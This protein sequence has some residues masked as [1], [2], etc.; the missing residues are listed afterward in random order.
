MVEERQ[1]LNGIGRSLRSHMIILVSI[2]VLMWLL[3][4]IDWLFFRQGL[5]T[6]GVRPRTMSG[7]FSIFLMPL[8]HGGFDHLLANTVPLLFLGWL[9]M[10]RR[11]TDFFVV[12]FIV[13]VVSGFG[14]WLL[15]GS[16]TIHIGA[17][18]LIFGYFGYLLARGFFDRSVASFLL[19]GVVLFFYS[20]LIF[21]ILPIFQSG[22]SWQGHLFGFLGG[23]WA[24]SII[25]KRIRTQE[26]QQ[27]EIEINFL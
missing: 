22:V 20:S 8:L 13:V 14:V 2:V 27:E 4:G 19:T 18:G 25:T 7:L 3:E 15:G 9:V 1:T 16:N 10:L 12:T 5:N 26:L 24:A 21:G 23:I 11:M 6:L 17:S